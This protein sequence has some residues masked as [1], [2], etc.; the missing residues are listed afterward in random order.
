MTI[1]IENHMRTRVKIIACVN[2]NSIFVVR[3]DFVDQNI[4]IASYVLRLA[5]YVRMYYLNI[6]MHSARW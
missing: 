1:S 6:F 4:M 5:S 3:M 2:N